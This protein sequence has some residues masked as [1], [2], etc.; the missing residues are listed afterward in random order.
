MISEILTR[1]RFLVTAKTQAEVDDELRFHLEHLTEANMAAGMPPEEARRQ[2]A[3]A[4]GGVERTREECR[5]QRP[6]RFM[7]AV[8][9]DVRYGLRTLRK[10]PG[11]TTVVIFTLALGIGAN[12]AMFSV[13]RAVLLKPLQYRDPDRLVR[14]VLAVPRRN[15][16]DQAFNEVRFEEMQSASHS[17]SKLGAFGPLENLTLSGSGEPEVVNAGRVSANFLNILGVEPVLG[18]SFLPDEDRH[19]GPAAAMIS[20]ELWRRR[21]NGD[22]QV[23]GKSTALDEVS[24]TIIGVLPAG[25]AFPVADIDIW[26]TRPSEWSALPSGAWRTVGLLKGFA[27]L[28]PLVNLE[29]ARAEMS[30]LQKRYA[31]A[32][33]NPVDADPSVTMGVVPLRDQL[34]SN[35]RP[36][37]WMLFGAV[38]FLLLI[39]CANV[40]SLSLARATSRSREFAVRAAIGATRRRLVGQLLAESLLLAVAGGAGGVLL[41][42]WSLHAI[43]RMDA[44]NLP[45]AAEIRLDGVVLGFALVVSI[46]TGIL[47]GLFPS[48][49][50]SRPNIAGILREGIGA[51]GR[52]AWR[53]L[54]SRAALVVGQVALSTVLLIGAALLLKSFAR[55]HSVDPGFR[56]SNLLTLR[57]ALPRAK[58][59]TDAKKKA[60]FQELMRRVTAVPGVQSATAALSLPTKNSLYTN[61][62]KVEG[63]D[64]ADK[65]FG[66]PDM[67]LQSVTPSY[68]QTLGIPLQRGREFT[69]GDNAPGAPPVVMINESLARLFWPNYP[70]GRDP[71]GRHIWEGAD[72]AIGELEIV[73]VVGDVHERGLTSEPRPE[74]YVPLIVHPPQRAYLAARTQGADPLGL[75]NTIRNEVLAID[76]DQ[77]V[78]DVH[79]ME[80]VIEESVGQRR[81]TMVLVG[82]FASVALLL[83]VV[84]IYGLVAYSVALRTQEVGIRR[85]LGAQTG[86]ILRLVLS[87]GLALAISGVALGLIGTFAL[88]R[89]MKEFLFQISATDPPTF[90]G[91]ALLFVLVVL[92]ASFIPARR[93]ARGDPLLA[94][95]VG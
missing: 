20:S 35:V 65:D 8:V 49:S 32:H 93:A 2:A 57:I 51:A 16:P 58:Y 45:R 31:L 42:K 64:L 74:F 91:V 18:R 87:Q 80:E 44:L 25:F 4:F 13:I 60:F 94:L 89:V 53:F 62:M 52:G 38:G 22:P 47:F 26:V 67:Q 41:E 46:A 1:L 6:G 37:L 55:L 40:A 61:I 27:R 48:L 15:V 76:R 84:G 19:G 39:A 11:F 81:L 78:S 9:Q 82:L 90:V 79:T 77:A 70:T 17:F 69:A 72:K 33:P 59:D 21:F 66:L 7:E 3:I 92:A 63:V 5:E 85:A 54:S 14:L 75:A 43:V 36:M 68:F 83:S 95:R 29:Q 30:V 34:V 23:V 86:D 88:T 71:I 28:N 50:V 24:Y 12:A 56:P 10:D 73:G